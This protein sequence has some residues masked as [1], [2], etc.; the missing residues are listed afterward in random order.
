MEKDNSFLLNMMSIK[1]KTF[2]MIIFLIIFVIILFSNLFINSDVLVASFNNINQPPSFNHIFGTDWMGRDMFFR[3][4]LGL[5]LSMKVGVFATIISTIMAICIAIF[6]SVNKFADELVSGIIDLFSAI[7]FILLILLICICLGGGVKGVILSIGLTHWIPLARILRAEIKK[8]KTK[9]YVIISEQ[10]GH[11]KL[12]VA[13]NHILP[14]ILSQII[15]GIIL[16]FPHAIMH[17]A[18]ISFLGF[19]LSPHE[20]SIGIILSES[21]HYLSLGY[22]WLAVF[23][24]LMLLIIVLFFDILGNQIYKFMEG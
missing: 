21:I 20:P 23:P 15:L 22:W 8:I 10:L 24:G 6:S 16:V 11:N 17:E 2:I 3:T 9:E 5:S 19:G 12:W 18:C 1:I 7:P 4:M 13:K 14:L